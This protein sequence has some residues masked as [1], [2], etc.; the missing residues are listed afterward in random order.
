MREVKKGDYLLHNSGGQISAISI[1]QED[2]QSGT[3]PQELKSAQSD[4]EWDDDGWVIY[5]KYYDF[6]SGLSTSWFKDW[7]V[8]NPA[9][10][11]CFQVDGRLRLQYLCNLA[12]I[13]AEYILNMA[14]KHE[15]SR[16]AL[17]V[18]RTALES[19]Q[20]VATVTN[21]P[22]PKPEPAAQEAVI[23]IPVPSKVLHKVYGEGTV[24]KI[25]GAKVYV[26]FNGN[27]EKIF[28]FPMAVQMGYIKLIGVLTGT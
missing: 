24:T 16:D 21:H 12:S 18:L 10:D 2:C 6:S 15:H 1:V 23:Q 9:S 4:Y 22:V 13:H 14:I 11:S 26:T 8:K 28:K 17:D 5:T 19:V 7:A 27:K 20:G 25:E 3:Q